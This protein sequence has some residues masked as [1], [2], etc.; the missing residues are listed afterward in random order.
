MTDAIID[1]GP[2]K[3]LFDEKDKYSASIRKFFKNFSGQLFTTLAVVTEVSYLLD[4]NKFLQLGFIEWI[5]DNAIK[6]IEINN[7]DFQSILKYMT[8]YR[9]TPM[10]FA[11][12]SLVI[13]A[14]KLKMKRIISLDSDFEVYRTFTGKSFENLTA[15]LI[16]SKNR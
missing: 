7:D 16:Q 11:D 2:I 6:V 13:L 5:K 15:D 1:T 14:N 9:D 10:D 8:K 12:A 3:A 4:E